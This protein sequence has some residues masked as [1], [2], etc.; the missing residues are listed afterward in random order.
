M[1]NGK[2]TFV[3]ASTKGGSGKSII[4]SMIIPVLVADTGK[5]ITVYGI[6]DNNSIN[7]QSS[8]IDFKDLKTKDSENVIDETEIKNINSSDDIS[9]ID[10]GGGADTHIF[11]QAVK[12]SSIRG[13]IY[14]IPLGDDIE[15]VHNLTETLHEIKS[16]SKDA[17]IYLILNQVN[18]MNDES[19]KRQF[20]GIYGSEKYDVTPLDKKI[21]EQVEGIYF[22]EASPLFSILKNI[23]NITLLDA[24]IDA[25]ELLTD[26]D[27]KKVEWAKKG[28]E[29]FKKQ[30]SLVRLA[31][32]VLKLIE[33][34]Y[35]MKSIVKV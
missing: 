17:K 11:L 21:L 28:S 24:Y 4:A 31:Y 10:L 8:F 32:D 20:I 18:V 30:N 34:I 13:L 26:L 27:S 25:K 16:A 9:I 29:H 19:I 33:R 35:Q 3:V 1:K 5:K 2:T 15:Q 6:D 23:Y 22:L 14:L 7:I 12:K